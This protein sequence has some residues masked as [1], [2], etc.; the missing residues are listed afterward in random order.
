[1]IV[2]TSLA[3]ESPASGRGSVPGSGHS[4]YA[5]YRHTQTADLPALDPL[6]AAFAAAATPK[7]TGE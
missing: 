5:Y 1:M 2:N 7:E 4:Q 3:P 6:L